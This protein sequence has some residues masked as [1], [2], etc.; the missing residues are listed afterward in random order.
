MLIKQASR[1][2]IDAYEQLVG[3]Y[4]DV[5]FRSAYLITRDASAAED[6]AQ[7]AFIRAY[8]GMPRF[9]LG[10]PFRPW[11][12]RI[13]TNEAHRRVA[14]TQ[15][16]NRLVLELAGSVQGLGYPPGIGRSVESEV[17]A[18]ELRE[19]LHRA[20]DELSETDK[21]V[22]AYRFVL[23]LS[24]VEMATAMNC[25]PGTVKS[26]LSRALNRLRSALAVREPELL[27]MRLT[28]G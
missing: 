22:L 7:E 4:Q 28:D 16:Q 5:A 26:R 19:Q 17:L 6:A 25:R 3:R 2:D 8:R 24:E 14:S 18:G 12:L 15:R 27:R 10:S 9:R 11:L 23:D 21:L 1:G 13:V 20:I